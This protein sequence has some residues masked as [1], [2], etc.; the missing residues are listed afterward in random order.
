MSANVIHAPNN[1]VFS[2]SQ[3]TG[4]EWS[5]VIEYTGE[6]HLMEVL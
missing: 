6:K 5:N 1:K 3:K 4:D 2:L